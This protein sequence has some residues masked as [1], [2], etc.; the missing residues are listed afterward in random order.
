MTDE[1][2]LSSRYVPMQKARVTVLWGDARAGNVSEVSVSETV[3][4]TAVN[5][6][7]QR[8]PPSAGPMAAAFDRDAATSRR[9]KPG[10]WSG[11]KPGLDPA[12]QTAANLTGAASAATLRRRHRVF[13]GGARLPGLLRPS[14]TDG[15]RH[16]I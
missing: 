15:R 12:I 8:Q 11:V 9:R 5:R 16:R 10:R 2:S 4:T 7:V 13:E 3:L 1:A 14:P 6:H